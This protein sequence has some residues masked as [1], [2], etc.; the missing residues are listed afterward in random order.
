MELFAE[1]I[2]VYHNPSSA[3]AP[4]YGRYFGIEGCLMWLKV[5][6]D[7]LGATT[8]PRLFNFSTSGNYV[9]CEVELDVT[10]KS[11]GKAVTLSRIVKFLFNADGKFTVWDIMEDSAPLVEVRVLCAP[12]CF[13]VQNCAL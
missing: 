7:E 12:E 3:L 4:M 1:N 6:R 9:F 11:T 13:G 8:A 5:C 10:V 2:V